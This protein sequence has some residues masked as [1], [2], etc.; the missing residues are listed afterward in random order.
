MNNFYGFI[1]YYCSVH[2]LILV[3]IVALASALYLCHYTVLLN[4]DFY[5][6]D[7]VRIAIY[8]SLRK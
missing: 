3:S 4:V 6:C 5:D 2:G 7:L 8:F 1:V